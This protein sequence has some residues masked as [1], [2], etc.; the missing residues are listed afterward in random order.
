M[1]LKELKMEN[2]YLDPYGQ[3]FPYG[4][5]V[6]EIPYGTSSDEVK[7]K[8]DDECQDMEV[9]DSSEF[10]TSAMFAQRE[11]SVVRAHVLLQIPAIRMPVKEVQSFHVENARRALPRSIV[12]FS[13]RFDIASTVT[14]FLTSAVVSLLSTI[15]HSDSSKLVYVS[16]FS[17]CMNSMLSLGPLK[18][19]ILDAIKHV[20]F[21]EENAIRV[22]SPHGSEHVIEAAPTGEIYVVSPGGTERIVKSEEILQLPIG[23]PGIQGHEADSSDTTLKRK[24]PAIFVAASKVVSL[25][26]A[27]A[28]VAAPITFNV[29]SS[30]WSDDS[31]KLLALSYVSSAVNSCTAIIPMMSKIMDIYKRKG[32]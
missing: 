2:I 27:S 30:V 28:G 21:R 25:I 9:S 13:K 11:I 20:K 6:D 18:S 19:R 12:K 15:W 14:G 1:N 23:A 4:K 26:L 3:E 7:C 32:R 24:L 22:V 8:P 5:L 17:A 16:R 10:P 29:L 31:E